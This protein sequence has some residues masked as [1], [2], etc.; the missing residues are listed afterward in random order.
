MAAD[1]KGYP[2]IPFIHEVIEAA[3]WYILVKCIGRGF[4]HPIHTDFNS[5]MLSVMGHDAAGR[6][7]P[8]SMMDRA[9]NAISRPDFEQRVL[10]ASMSVGM[11]LG[12]NWYI[13]DLFIDAK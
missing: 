12:D 10:E 13:N 6:K 11:L 2:L 5:L 8:G 4:K 7:M 1:D 3:G 9:K